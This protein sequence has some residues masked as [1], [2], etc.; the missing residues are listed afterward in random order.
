MD[1]CMDGR[2]DEC[3]DKSIDR[4]NAWTDRWMNG[5]NFRRMEGEK[6]RGRE[7]GIGGQ[8]KFPFLE[9][10]SLSSKIFVG[11]AFF[12]E[13]TANFTCTKVAGKSL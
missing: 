11:S 4:A 8:M 12:D 2:T 6:E 5:W 3:L 1:E 7:R 10:I 9:H 13:T